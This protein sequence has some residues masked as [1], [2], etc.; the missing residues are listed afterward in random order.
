MLIGFSTGAFYKTVIGKFSN[1]AFSLLRK[2]DTN[3]I[4]LSCLDVNDLSDLGSIRPNT[5]SSFKFKSLHAP[6]LEFAYKDEDDTHQVLE[7]IKSL[8]HRFSFDCIIFHPDRIENWDVFKKYSALPIAIENMN[9]KKPAGKTVQQMRNILQKGDFKMLL[10][11]Q[12]CYSND[13]T[14]Q[15]AQDM[16][17]EFKSIIVELHLSGQT[18]IPGQHTPLYKTKQIQIIKA[19]PDRNIPLIIESPVEKS[20]EILQEYEYI[21]RS[22]DTP[23]S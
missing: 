19:I 1:Q 3:A 20:D 5:V 22:I 11:L 7:H 6:A 14:L 10:D 15:L 13:P 12:H 8:H 17:E 23:L 2:C 16:Y 9:S 18:N 21:R 4:E